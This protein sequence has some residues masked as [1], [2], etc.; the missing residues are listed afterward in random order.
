MKRENWVVGE[1]SV[2]PAGDPDKCFYCGRKVGETHEPTCVIR[3]RTAVVDV[4]VRMVMTFPENFNPDHIEWQYNEGSWC[5][6]NI[7]DRLDDMHERL[8]CLCDHFELKF[9]R[10]AT[11]QDE[12]EHKV[13][14]H[15]SES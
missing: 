10:E 8:G 3:K 1:Y 14:V 13:Y 11:E 9:V 7:I 5:A 15:E 6:S 12:I 4:T 2:R